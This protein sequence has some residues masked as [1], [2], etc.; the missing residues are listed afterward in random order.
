MDPL[1]KTVIS[2]LFLNTLQSAPKKVIFKGL[3]IFK[4][5]RLS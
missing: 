2:R 5:P 3:G 1:T 4:A